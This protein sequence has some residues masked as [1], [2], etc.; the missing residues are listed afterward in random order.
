MDQHEID[1][2]WGDARVRGHLN[3]TGFYTGP[4]VH[5]SLQPPAWSFGA[6]PEQADGLL[7]L[8]LDGTKTATA[9]A[10]W[11]YEAEDEALPERGDLSII[12]D[13]AGHP[14]AL[15]RVTDVQ[16]LPFDQVP[17][18]HAWLEGEDDRSLESWRRIHEGFFREHASHERE[19]SADMPVVLE[20]FE[21][22]YK[23]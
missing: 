11:D 12:L 22:L 17:A 20:R 15:I 6:T 14:R 3:R 9:G 19:F 2:F 18:E 13:G 5:E 21:V 4:T 23:R 7:A 16:V 1:A 10:L 8:V